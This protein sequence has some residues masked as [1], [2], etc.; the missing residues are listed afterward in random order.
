LDKLSAGKNGA[1]SD[2]NFEKVKLKVTDRAGVKHEI[3][4]ESGTQ[5]RDALIR[6]QLSPYPAPRINLNCKGLGICG[7][8][9]VII[10]ENAEDW[11]KRS[12]QIQCFQDLELRLK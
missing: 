6:H 5:L 7:T 10:R 11:E 1:V 3:T 2:Q 9:K 4:V 8:C 12:C